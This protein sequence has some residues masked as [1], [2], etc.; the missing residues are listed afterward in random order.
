MCV[1][2]HN[3]YKCGNKVSNK[4]PYFSFI[5]KIYKKHGKHADIDDITFLIYRLPVKTLYNTLC[6]SPKKST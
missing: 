1:D 2:I 5:S 4:D 6:K 3:V